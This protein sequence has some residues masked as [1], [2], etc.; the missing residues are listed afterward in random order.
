MLAQVMPSYTQQL[1]YALL[2]SQYVLKAWQLAFT[3]ANDVLIS[4]GYA[5]LER[6]EQELNPYKQW[7]RAQPQPFSC[8]RAPDEWLNWKLPAAVMRAWAAQSADPR[9]VI[10]SVSMPRP[11]V[12]CF[13]LLKLVDILSSH[14]YQ[15]YALPVVALM[16]AV[17]TTTGSTAGTTASATAA[18]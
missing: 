4:P 2:A 1:E 18:A 11:N 16:N 8:P 14:G 3:H 10:G 5:L 13:H 6:E 17:A 7:L 15:L 9:M 12:T